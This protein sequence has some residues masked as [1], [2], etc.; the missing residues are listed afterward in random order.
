MTTKTYGESTAIASTPAFPGPWLAGASLLLGPVL[1]CTGT[2]LRL[3]V[4]FFFPHQLAAYE[5]QPTLI[6][7]AYGTFLAGVTT[8]WPG[9][10]ALAA[11][12]GAT[13]PGRWPAGNRPRARSG[14]RRA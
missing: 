6:M 1:L 5:R 7:V 3:G 4:P 10:M 9:V 14:R 2:V 13:R 12:I 11:R 8:L